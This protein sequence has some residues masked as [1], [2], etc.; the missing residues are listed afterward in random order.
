VVPLETLKDEFYKALD[1]D[2]TT[3]N[4]ADDL[5]FKLGIEK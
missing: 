3:G 5:L 1:Y 2:L 4:P